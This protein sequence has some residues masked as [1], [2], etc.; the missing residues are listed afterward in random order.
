MSYVDGFVIPISK[1]KLPEY[2]KI[3]K[4]AGKIWM[5]HG[6]VAYFECAGDDLKSSFGIPFTKLANVKAGETVMFSYVVYKNKAHRDKVNKKVMADP[7][8]AEMCDPE[9]SPFDVKRMAYGGFKTI[10]QF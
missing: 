5:E 7:R 9:N 2:T 3:A 10:A 1:K 8:L 4:M 6:A